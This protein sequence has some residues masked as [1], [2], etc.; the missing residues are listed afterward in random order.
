MWS[1][2]EDALLAVSCGCLKGNT[3]KKQC[4]LIIKESL[5]AITSSSSGLTRPW[6]WLFIEPGIPTQSSGISQWAV[7]F[8]TGL[9]QEM[10]PVCFR[11]PELLQPQGAFAVKRLKRGSSAFSELQNYDSLAQD[12]LKVLNEAVVVWFFILFFFPCHGAV[13]LD[14]ITEVEMSLRD[15]S[16]LMKEGLGSRVCGF[17]VCGS[18]CLHW[19]P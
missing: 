19:M 4:S 5:E 6:L 14:K 9:P 17:A 11:T 8:L 1:H 16:G 13:S 7:P 10:F 3:Y 2:T 12:L 15:I 18:L